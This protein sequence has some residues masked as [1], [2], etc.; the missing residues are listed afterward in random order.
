[1]GFGMVE[2]VAA[3]VL[4]VKDDYALVIRRAIIDGDPWS[5][6]IGLPGGHVEKGETSREAARREC[7]EEVGIDPKIQSSIG[8]FETHI[9]GI[10][11]EAFLGTGMI[12]E[13]HV[14]SPEVSDVILIR[15]SDIRRVGNEYH[16]VLL[17]KDVIWGLTYRIMSA[18]FEGRNPDTYERRRS[19][20]AED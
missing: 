13:A 10:A 1:M 3:V 20:S 18:F 16:C 14:N 15:L 7:I 4:L 5:G 8:I 6:Q 9:A 19:Y 17:G 11:V 2:P 12:D